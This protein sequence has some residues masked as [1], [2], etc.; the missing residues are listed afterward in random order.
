MRAVRNRAV[1]AIIWPVRLD[2][3]ALVD[4]VQAVRRA[5]RV[6]R[7][8]AALPGAPEVDAERA[9]WRRLAATH[10]A[11][12]AG[13]RLPAGRHAEAA[14]GGLQDSGPRDGLLSLHA[15]MES[16]GPGAWEHPDLAQVWLRWADYIVPRADVD[17]FTLGA[18][19]REA[20]YRAAVDG[21]GEMVVRAIDAD[22]AGPGSDGAGRRRDSSAVIRDLPEV[23]Y[24]PLVRAA[25]ASGRVHIRWDART[26]DIVA[27]EHRPLAEDGGPAGLDAAGPG[28]D[29]EELRLALARRFVRWLGPVGPRHLARWAGLTRKDAAETW[30]LLRP[31]L[32]PVSLAG[33]AR[34][35]LA[36]DLDGL[37]GAERPAGVRFLPGG[38]PALSVPA[39]A[40]P[41][42]EP[43]E[44]D[45]ARRITRR[46][47][48]SLHGRI[49]VDGAVV[50]A[51]GRAQRKLTIDAWP[52]LS[53]DRVDE[54]A[55]EAAALAGPMGGEMAVRWLERS[56]TDT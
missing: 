24:P 50:G 52:G 20:R 56:V 32:A 15:R 13:S 54:V 25:T 12:P 44:P 46:L 53:R 8:P 10:A 36:S 39:D 23:P 9:Q 6:G 48:N 5:N 3:D 22:P 4:Y 49:V 40:P 30:E 17:V 2:A 21:L 11:P 33:R 27:V 29:V 35:V 34:W 1:H 51:W 41:A 37:L 43:L 14:H 38:D 45:E 42:P 26:T 7:E 31:E 28:L 47:V 18:R 55:A 19:P 16:V